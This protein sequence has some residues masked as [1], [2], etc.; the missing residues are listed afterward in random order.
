[1][2]FFFRY[3]F[4]QFE[5]KRIQFMK[6]VLGFREVLVPADGGR[7]YFLE[8]VGRS[9]LPT[10]V[11]VHGFLDAS[12]GFRKLLQHLDYPGR[13][14]VPDLPGYG[15][16]RDPKQKFEYHLD[17][18]SANL[19]SALETIRVDY[20]ECALRNERTY[21]ADLDR[22]VR[23]DPSSRLVLCGHSMGGLVVQNLLL[24]YCK[25]NPSAVDR[26][27]LLATGGIRHRRRDEMRDILLPKTSEG[28]KQLLEHLYHDSPPALTWIEKRVLLANWNG[29]E[30]QSLA[31]NT[32]RREEEI[33]LEDRARGIHVP[34]L[35][36]VGEGDELSTVAMMHNYLSWIPQSQL[37][38]LP[39]TRHALHLERPEQVARLISEFLGDLVK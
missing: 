31:K 21:Q 12:Y 6:D 37:E 22:N 36:V 19:Y 26:A 33:F 38:V 5:R 24:T 2:K 9:D 16:S 32:I 15:R 35:L 30:N 17:R 7:V 1:M 3:L 27:V 13:I 28:I 8:K 4:S 20:R 39:R 18:M 14:L 23:T 29:P 25:T 11:L 34:T 10:L